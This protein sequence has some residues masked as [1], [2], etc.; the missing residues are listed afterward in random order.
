MNEEKLNKKREKKIEKIEREREKLKKR[1]RNNCVS[2]KF[3]CRT[4]TPS[5][6]QK[7]QSRKRKK[8]N[9]INW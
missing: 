1:E 8:K 9:I 4:L 2:H 7:M 6:K 3:H 5:S